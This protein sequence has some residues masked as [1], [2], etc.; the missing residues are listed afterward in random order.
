MEVLLPKT[1]EQLVAEY[2]YYNF[3]NSQISI[4]YLTLSEI[5]ELFPEEY[6]KLIENEI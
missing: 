4:S 2:N 1:T 5:K 3:P 6:E